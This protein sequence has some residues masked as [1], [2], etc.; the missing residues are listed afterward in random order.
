MTF[1]LVCSQVEDTSSEP[2]LVLVLLL[3]EG[4]MEGNLAAQGNGCYRDQLLWH[5]MGVPSTR[6]TEGGSSSKWST[7]L[8]PLKSFSLLNLCLL[9]EFLLLL[10]HLF[11]IISFVISNI[12]YSFL[13]SCGG[14]SWFISHA[15]WL[16]VPSINRWLC[17]FFWLSLQ[18][19]ARVTGTPPRLVGSLQGA[20]SCYF[21]IFHQSCIFQG[22]SRSP[23]TAKF[24]KMWNSY[25]SLSPF[26]FSFLVTLSYP[27]LLSFAVCG[28]QDCLFPFTKQ[29]PFYYITPV[30]TDLQLDPKHFA[31]R[32]NTLQ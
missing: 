9:F 18:L 21:F 24:C 6:K 2:W 19:P 8:K 20:V 31:Y 1:I 10:F 7:R 16:G 23:F 28:F 5:M 27:H 11:C 13:F 17:L 4:P 32:A 25:F 12:F 30:P 15:E 26:P 22:P 29:H 3:L 14:I